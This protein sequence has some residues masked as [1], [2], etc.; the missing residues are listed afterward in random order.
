M[1]HTHTHAHTHTHTPPPPQIFS[2]LFLLVNIIPPLV[3]RTN[4]SID[5]ILA[6]VLTF[7]CSVVARR[8]APYLDA[9]KSI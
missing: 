6:A 1:T 9:V 8:V 3:L 7:L 2:V 5:L 4:F